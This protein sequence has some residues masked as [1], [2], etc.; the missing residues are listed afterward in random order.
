[1]GIVPGG[2][3]QLIMMKYVQNPLEMYG[4]GSEMERYGLDSW[5][6]LD[7]SEKCRKSRKIKVLRMRFSIV[8]NVPMSDDIIFKLSRGSQRPYGAKS[9]KSYYLPIFILLDPSLL[10]T[11]GFHHPKAGPIMHI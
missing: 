10:S 3:N 11:W 6:K 9:K 1:M 4:M 5:E 8:E 2:K 7:I